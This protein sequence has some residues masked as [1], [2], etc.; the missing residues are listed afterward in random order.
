MERLQAN[1]RHKPD[2]MVNITSTE[3][4]LRLNLGLN[5]GCA[6]SFERNIFISLYYHVICRLI[7]N[8]LK[9]IMV[10]LED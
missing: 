6:L 5:P 2:D 4:Q 1:S 9:E 3:C 7:F 8:V 10:A